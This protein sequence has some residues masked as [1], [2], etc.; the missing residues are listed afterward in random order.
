[1]SN[2][3]IRPVVEL[4]KG[5]CRENSILQIMCVGTVF[6]SLGS[7]GPPLSEVR[8]YLIK[9]LYDLVNTFFFQNSEQL[10]ILCETHRM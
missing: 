7:L 10:H 5:T 8:I 4:L 2:A 9:R 1:M 3:Q 6:Y